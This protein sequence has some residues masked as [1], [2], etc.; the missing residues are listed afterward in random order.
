MSGQSKPALHLASDNNPDSILRLFARLL[1]RLNWIDLLSLLHRVARVQDYRGAFRNPAENL[2][3]V[4]VIPP[5]FDFL[6]MHFMV[7]TDGRYLRPFGAKHQSLAWDEQ[8]RL[9]TRT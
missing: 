9:I 1:R 3:T 2:Q 5:H 7:G 4:A 6:K 8:G